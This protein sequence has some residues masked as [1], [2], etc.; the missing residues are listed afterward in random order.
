MTI[1]VNIPTAANWY[2]AQD[3]AGKTDR[4]GRL[5]DAPGC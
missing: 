1:F 5:S 3:G 4:Y 2:Y